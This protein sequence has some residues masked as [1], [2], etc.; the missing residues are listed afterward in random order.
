MVPTEL[1][2]R[3]LVAV[4]GIPIAVAAIYLGGWVLGGVLALV[5]AGGAVEVY[6]LAAANG[7]RA[8]VAPG[9][10][11]S[12]LYV[13]LAAARPDLASVASAYW[14]LTLGL[15]LGVGVAALPLRGTEGRPLTS[16]AVTVTGALLTGGTLACALF[17]R[18][19][20]SEPTAGPAPFGIGSRDAWTGAAIVAFPIALTWINDSCAFFVGRRFGRRKLVPAISPGKTVEGAIG[21][22]V[23]T[24]L[25]GLGYAALVLDRWLGLPFSPALGAAAGV[26]ISIVAQ[27][28]DLVES[29]LK[30][31]ARVKDSGRIFPGHGGILDRFDAL[32]F[33]LPVMYWYLSVVVA[34]LGGAP[35]R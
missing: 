29:L 5:A 21:G 34:A 30:R 27:I 1:S 35:W 17:L 4:V 22:L 3:V 20:I 6:R 24:V 12:G 18:H 19:F 28:G 26:L 11:A 16:I 33:T 10:L 7:V 2:Q 32:F 13:L 25:I 9:A 14:G 31:E 8:F 23:G 15:L